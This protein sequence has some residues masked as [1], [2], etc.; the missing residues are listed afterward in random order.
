M[1]AR[2]IANRLHGVKCGRYV[3]HRTLDCLYLDTFPKDD[4]GNPFSTGYIMHPNDFI[5]LC[6]TVVELIDE[7]PEDYKHGEP[8]CEAW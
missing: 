3:L 8:V 6:R 5:A 2:E 7:Y 1:N 4:I